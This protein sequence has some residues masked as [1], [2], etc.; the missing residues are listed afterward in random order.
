MRLTSVFVLL[1]ITVLSI[2]VACSNSGSD[3]TTEARIT[4]EN[5]G[6]L[7][8]PDGSFVLS[9]PPGAVSEDVDIAFKQVSSEDAP[10]GI[11]GAEGNGYE[12]TPDGLQ[13]SEPAH[14]TLTI[15]IDELEID[16]ETQLATA[17]DLYTVDSDGAVTAIDNPENQ[18]DLAEGVLTLTADISHFSKLFRSKRNISISLSQIQGAL[19]IGQKVFVEGVVSS[20]GTSISHDTGW[21][22]EA[23]SNVELDVPNTRVLHREESATLTQELSF[24]G[25]SKRFSGDVDLRPN[26]GVEFHSNLICT[27]VG[28][29]IYSFSVVATPVITGSSGANP[30]PVRISLTAKVSCITVTD[31]EATAAASIQATLRAG[32]ADT[33]FTPTAQPFGFVPTQTPTPLPTPALEPTVAATATPTPRPGPTPTQGPVAVPGEITL[34]VIANSGELVPDELAVFTG[35]EL[36]Q[37]SSNT[38]ALFGFDDTGGRGIWRFIQ[39]SNGGAALVAFAQSYSPPEPGQYAF[40]ESQAFVMN[41]AGSLAFIGRLRTDIDFT[42]GLFLI[43][44]DGSLV[45]VALEGAGKSVV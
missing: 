27:S 5:G 25:N 8:A 21:V 3:L 43:N 29:G 28:T 18:F 13:F 24:T 11:P 17:F 31:A 6:E 38:G 41:E 1:S 16:A 22:F 37:V 40:L 39:D 9:V 33:I 30:R 34:R 19:A 42:D 36:P 7:R 14:V 44:Q 26:Q 32:G 12:L 23:L 20:N 2:S 4:V 15:P 35:F 10:T 45:E